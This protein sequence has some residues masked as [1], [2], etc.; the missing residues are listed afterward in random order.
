MKPHIYIAGTD[1]RE[2]ATYVRQLGAYGYLEA[3]NG[4][5]LAD[6]EAVRFDPLLNR[7]DHRLA[8]EELKRR[9][10]IDSHALQRSIVA[11]FL[12]CGAP[13]PELIALWSRIGY[14]LGAVPYCVISGG[15]DLLRMTAFSAL[16]TTF[17]THEQ[18]WQYIRK[19]SKNEFVS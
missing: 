10:G 19:I 11:W 18:A 7:P 8:A 6:D 9:A 5:G 1:T 3:H 15:A 4:L 16:A 2:V 17:P 12:L 13:E 14:A